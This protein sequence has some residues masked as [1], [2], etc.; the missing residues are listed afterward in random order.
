[1]GQS[2]SFSQPRSKP[3][4]TRAHG[5]GTSRGP[6]DTC[7]N[8][9][10]N[11][12]FSL[13]SANFLRQ[14]FQTTETRRR[15]SSTDCK[16][17]R[18]LASPRDREHT[19][20]TA[21][22]LGIGQFPSQG[23]LRIKSFSRPAANLLYQIMETPDTARDLPARNA[24]QTDS[25]PGGRLASSSNHIRIKPVSSMR[26]VKRAPTAHESGWRFLDGFWDKVASLR[27]QNSA[28]ACDNKREGPVSRSEKFHLSCTA[29]PPS[30]SSQFAPS[31]AARQSPGTQP[32]STR[33]QTGWTAG[34]VAPAGIALQ[35]SAI[36][37]RENRG[38]SGSILERRNGPCSHP[39]IH[40]LNWPER[41]EHT[42]VPAGLA[43]IRRSSRVVRSIIA[44]ENCRSTQQTYG[45]AGSLAS[46][47]VRRLGN[48]ILGGRRANHHLR[49]FY[50]DLFTLRLL[51]LETC[52]M[53]ASTRARTPFRISIGRP[54]NDA[55]PLRAA[56]SAATTRSMLAR[57]LA[58]T[59]TRFLRRGFVSSLIHT[60]S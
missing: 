3:R 54:R 15:S 38:G 50:C 5:S 23:R 60:A 7:A 33:W 53:R 17:A 59:R 4:G 9:E 56:R 35:K 37:A 31:H 18:S 14:N 11:P 57:L 42:P 44:C 12:P 19:D 26:I 46:S 8:A 27:Q 36:S 6:S 32:D 28:G 49:L 25:Q 2:A 34:V 22:G 52:S 20:A 16:R 29:T 21:N 41:F 43:A 48:P 13:Q 55:V 1:M 39:A 51:D 30:G 40:R 45:S 10:P 58:Q 24:S 47:F